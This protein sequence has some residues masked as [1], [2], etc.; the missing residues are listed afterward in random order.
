MEF[1]IRATKKKQ[2]K[3]KQNKSKKKK[4]KEKTDTLVFLTKL[5]IARIISVLSIVKK[6]HDIE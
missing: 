6:L 1:Y 5:Q 4:K 2:N 3:T